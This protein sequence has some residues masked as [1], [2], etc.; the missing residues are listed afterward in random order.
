MDLWTQLK[1]KGCLT[2]E[3]LLNSGDKAGTERD[4]SSLGKMNNEEFGERN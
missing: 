1:A 2:E 4:R 3:Q